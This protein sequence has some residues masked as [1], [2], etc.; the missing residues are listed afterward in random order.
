MIL[1]TR[2]AIEGVAYSPEKV[3]RTISSIS[4]ALTP[5]DFKAF[6]AA[7]AANSYDVSTAAICLFLIPVRE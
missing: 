5:E 3:P 2:Q 1:C 4:S 6:C 7:F